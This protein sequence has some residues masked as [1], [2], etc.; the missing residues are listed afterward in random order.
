V[1]LDPRNFGHIN[2][3]LVA[4]PEMFGDG[5]VLRL[6]VA[7]NFAANDRINPDNN[8]GYFDVTY[9]MNDDNPNTKF[10]KGQVEQGNFKK[11]T[12]LQILYRLNQ[13]RWE[14]D[15]QKYSKVVLIAETI[16]YGN[17]GGRSNEGSQAS[18]SSG[19]SSSGSDVAEVPVEF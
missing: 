6:R 2:C 18:A 10:V 8:S 3:G 1:S 13:D 5:K 19:G 14:K 12:S 11:G 16:A 7:A 17:T 9:F 4:D 15:G